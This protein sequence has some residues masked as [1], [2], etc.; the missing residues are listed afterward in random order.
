MTLVK[1]DTSLAEIPVVKDVLTQ[2]EYE[3]FKAALPQWRDQLIAMLLRNTGLRINELLR[4]ETRHFN[5][6]GPDYFVYVVRSKKR[7]KAPQ[8]EPLY[9]V[10]N[11]GVQLRNYIAGSSYRQNERVFGNVD[12][13]RDA[14]KIT[15][16]GLR[17]AFAQAGVKAIGRPI[18]TREFRAFFIQ[19]LV[20]GRVPMEMAAAMVGHEDARTTQKHYY[21]LSA[22][23]RRIIGE[24]IPV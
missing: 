11:L 15:A 8:Y 18:A 24:G 23:R 5:L 21:R 4:L 2:G 12:G 9:L 16:R 13:Q 22:D 7:D 14:R 6:A 1:R 17:F 3:A 20:D 10:S 19:T